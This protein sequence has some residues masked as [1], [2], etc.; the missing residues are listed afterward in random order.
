MLDLKKRPEKPASERPPAS[1][2]K[3]FLRE[4]LECTNKEI[5]S[6]SETGERTRKEFQRTQ[7]NLKDG[8]VSFSCSVIRWDPQSPTGS[9]S[10]TPF[11]SSRRESRSKIDIFPPNRQ[12]RTS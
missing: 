6:G 1:F 10:S 8:K 11:F 2:L 3:N 9:N 12:P 5:R 4:N 7:G